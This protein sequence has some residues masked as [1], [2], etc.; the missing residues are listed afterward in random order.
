M[1]PDLQYHVMKKIIV[2][3]QM[4]LNFYNYRLTSKPQVCFIILIIKVSGYMAQ[5]KLSISL[6]NL[7]C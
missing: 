3:H 6:Y 4:S 5:Y 2:L 1:F 7:S